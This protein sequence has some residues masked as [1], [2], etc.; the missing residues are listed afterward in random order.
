MLGS[1]TG[2]QQNLVIGRDAIVRPERISHV[3]A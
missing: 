1:S 2:G 3:V